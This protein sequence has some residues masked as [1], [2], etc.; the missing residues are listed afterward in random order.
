M[1]GWLADQTGVFFV[2]QMA[3]SI[4][5]VAVAA[6]YLVAAFRGELRKTCVRDPWRHT[7]DPLASLA[8]SLGLLGSVWSFTVC[9]GG[10]VGEIDIDRITDGL[11]T[12]YVTTGFGLITSLIAGLATYVLGLLHRRLAPVLPERDGG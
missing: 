11:G 12:A 1:L 4:V 7:L 8:V 2:P 3:L 10:F 6:G 9:F 5:T